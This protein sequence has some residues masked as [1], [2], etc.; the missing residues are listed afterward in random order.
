MPS[1]QAR[2]FLGIATLVAAVLAGGF[3][4]AA[5]EFWLEVIGYRPKVGDE[6]PIVHRIGMEMQGL[7]YPFLGKD[8]KRFSILADGKEVAIK[9]VEG[10]EPAGEVIAE[11]PGLMTVIF[12]GTVETVEFAT[13]AKFEESLR[14]E[15]LEHIVAA[16]RKAA[17]PEANIVE[18]YVRCAKAL[19]GVG[20]GRG[21]DRFVGMPLEI[22][23]EANPYELE[24]GGQLPV[25]V[26]HEGKPLAGVTLKVFTLATAKNPVRVVTD[27][28]GRA[29]VVLERAGEHLLHAVHMREPRQGETGHWL[30]LWASLTFK[31]G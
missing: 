30:S 29:S 1:S 4:A 13:F 19:I 23:A 8:T 6:I 2:R 10:D 14:F 24:R 22:V 28:D 17:K 18:N 11:R 20:H 3:T 21:K 25:Q 15:H 27:K 16:H 9:S 26:L 12:H 7:S 5:H 31:A